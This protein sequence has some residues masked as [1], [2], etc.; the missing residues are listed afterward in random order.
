MHHTLTLWTNQTALASAADDAGIDRIGLD[1]ER[2]G[3]SRRQSGLATWVSDHQP[4]DLARIGPALRSAALF[5]RTNPLHAGSRD[6]IAGLL[7][8]G[9]SVLMLPNFQVIGEVEA[10][11]RLVDGRAQVVPLVERVRAVEVIPQLAALGIREIHVGLNDLGID[12]GMTHRLAPLVSPIMDR[13]AEQ[14]HRSGLGLAVG[15]IARALDES[16]PT[17]SDLIYA[18][19]VRLGSSGAMIAR[20][21]LRPREPL[22]DIGPA[23]A[24]ARRR[25]DEWRRSPSEAVLQAHRR[26]VEL[27][28]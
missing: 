21:F 14:T 16:L 10:Y 20:S 17:P 24:A 9:V 3:K 4:A 5:A 11:C 7:D 15:G 12:L 18:Q 22:T 6:E 25:L 8:A 26:L 28:S 13:I 23:V 27:V 1:L 2:L 19:Q